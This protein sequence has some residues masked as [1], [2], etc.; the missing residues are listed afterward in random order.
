MNEFPRPPGR[1][2]RALHANPALSLATKVVV[3][4]VGTLVVGVGV[5]MLVTP[6]PAVVV[7]PLGLAILAT[8]FDFA[9]RWLERARRWARDAKARAEAL[10]PRVRRRRTLLAVGA[11]VVVVGAVAWY[12]ATYD[13]PGWCVEGWDRLQ[14]LAPWVPDLP[15]M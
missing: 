12:V 11:L 7:I 10:D 4:V 8:E 14:S 3:G 13:W 2:H 5:A 6:G 1:L 15:G 9:R